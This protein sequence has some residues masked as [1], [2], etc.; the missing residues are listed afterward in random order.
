LE[1][2]LTGRKG[3]TK[4]HIFYEYKKIDKKAIADNKGKR[5]KAELFHESGN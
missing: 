2:I 1:K 5:N 3:I 4:I